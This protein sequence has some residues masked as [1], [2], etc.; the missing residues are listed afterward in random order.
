MDINSFKQ[1]IC[2][3]GNIYVPIDLLGKDIPIV[4]NSCIRGFYINREEFIKQ[5][6]FREFEY[7]LPPRNDWVS[8]CNTNETWIIFDKAIAAIDV[9]L[10]QQKSPLVWLKNKK[11]KT[12]SFFV[13]WW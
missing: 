12:Q 13:T 6:Y 4:S 7:F 10:N 1:K 8:D 2:L 5:K 11:N 3:K 9:L